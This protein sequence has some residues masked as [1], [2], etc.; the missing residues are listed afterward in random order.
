MCFL[1]WY[2]YN[3]LAFMKKIN[4]QLNMTDGSIAK[5]TL[6]YALPVLFSGWLQLLY[7]AADLITCG[8]FGSEH[9]VGAISA[10]SSLTSLIIS[11][12]M[13]F[14]VGANVLIAQAVGAKDKV[15]G[16]KILQMTYF[17]GIISSILLLVIGV[18]CSK[19]FLLAM[20]TPEDIIDLSN[21]YMTI[22]FIGIP[23]GIIYNFGAALM[24]GM[25]D[26]TKPF[27]FLL[28]SGAI[29]VGLNFL[30]V[31][32]FRMD[33]AGVATTTV[34]SEAISAFLVTFSLVRDRNSFV[35][36]RLKGFRPDGKVISSIV[37]IGIPAGLQSALFSLSNVVLQSSIN[38]FGSDAVTGTGAESSIESFLSNGVDA[39]A[40]A[41]VAFVGAN[42][43]AKNK[44]RITSSLI[45]S[46]LYGLLFSA[47]AGVFV[48]FCSDMLLHIYIQNE[49]A[50]SYGREKLR[51]IGMT[52]GLYS[53]VCT[54]SSAVR[55]LGYSITP[56]VI[57]LVGICVLR[58]IYIYTFFP[59]E[60]FHTIFGLYLSYP[61]SWGITALAHGISY[62]F[63]SKKA[64]KKMFV[65]DNVPVSDHL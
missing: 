15:K 2:V 31:I 51:I 36:L 16:E 49:A 17:L 48:Y 55:G 30:F 63:I 3:L 29:N 13:G 19:Y 65:P 7:S 10:T 60:A 54:I 37:K 12:F 52:Y 38:S 6:L 18:T 41:G 45:Y 11:L 23:F 61:I 9:S 50:I 1:F 22:Y 43:G 35:N 64:F 5:K 33:V 57:S 47:I 26:T 40:Q 4:T 44:K 34:I 21:T 25:G 28:F 46:S 56:M 24:R 39:F 59:M 58:I 14:S 42:Y 62:I 27:L 53:L 20:A 32:A 8:N